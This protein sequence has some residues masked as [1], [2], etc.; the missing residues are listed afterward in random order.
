[1]SIPSLS[2]LITNRWNK[3]VCLLTNGGLF[4][5]ASFDIYRNSG[6]KSG[7]VP[8]L[9]DVQSDVLSALD[10]R[11]VT[12]L[13]RRDRF[14]AVSLPANLMPILLVEGIEYVMETPKLAAVPTR[15][16]KTPVASLESQRFEIGGGVGFFV[17]GVLIFGCRYRDRHSTLITRH[18][19]VP[20]PSGAMHANRLSFRF[21]QRFYENHRL[22]SPCGP[23]N[24]R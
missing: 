12:P 8:Y 17:S 21:V 4:N 7:D 9:L 5:V 6:A 13:K 18:F 24:R 22:F 14:L 2:L 23:A 15:I 11:V 10:S 1:M 20:R 3:T 19:R 16:L